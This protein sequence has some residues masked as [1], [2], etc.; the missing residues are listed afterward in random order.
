VSAKRV[1]LARWLRGDGIEVGALHHPLAVPP[2]ANVRYVDHLPE[3]ELRRRYPELDGEPFAPISI[4]G[5]A[6]DLSAIGDESVDFVIAN[7]LLEHLENPVKGLSEF[8]RVLR[9]G[10]ILYLALPDQRQTF[11]RDRPLTS[12]EHLLD[13]Y[14]AGSADRNRRGHYVDWARHVTPL[15]PDAKVDVDP[16]EAA[17]TEADRLIGLHYSI[18]FHVWRPDT[19]LDFLVAARREAGLDLSLLAFAAPEH[20]DDNE[21]TMVL[22]KG[23][24]ERPRVLP[25]HAARAATA[26][27]AV[28]SQAPAPARGA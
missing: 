10:G 3:Q 16:N 17:E 7:H 4:I 2:G 1:H 18:H 22:A 11:D 20:P 8:H 24:P 15:T 23:Y 27:P 5:S 9:P 19:F 26:E 21:F 25:A 28:A 6:E 12:T 13:E 14:R